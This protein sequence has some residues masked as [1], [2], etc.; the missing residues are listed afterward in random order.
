MKIR[1][2]LCHIN[3]FAPFE[4]AEEW[5]N[6]GLLVGSIE[7][8][9]T[10]IG[11]CLDAVSEA[12]IE[13]ERQ[14]CNV[15]V[16]HH[17][18]IFRPAKRVTDETEQGRTII[19][20][21]KRNIA[22]IAAHTNWDKAQGGV[23]DILAGLIGIKNTEPLGDFGVFCSLPH[24]V[25]VKNFVEHVQLSWGLSHIDV[26][27]KYVLD[28]VSRAAICG[29]SGAS[30]WKTAREKGAD[31]YI[32]ADMKYHEII[33]ATK[34]GLIIALADHGEMER[35]SIPE[36]SRK[37]SLCGTETVIIDV[38]ALPKILSLRV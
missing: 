5:D 35:A 37:I 8:E 15:L 30:F 3:T 38:K 7:A 20:A 25:A 31:V 27:A 9:V 28:K 16:C 29:G 21:V 6:S 33:D 2:L 1:D 10:R 4:L 17:P 36:L 26:Y 18:L 11:V 23:N 22:I 32:T 34:E 12:V 24:T 13:A 19:E 14:G